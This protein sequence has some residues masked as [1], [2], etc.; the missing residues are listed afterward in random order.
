[1]RIARWLDN[2][3]FIHLLTVKILA[4]TFIVHVSDFITQNFAGKYF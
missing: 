4:G 3:A 2:A 1:M